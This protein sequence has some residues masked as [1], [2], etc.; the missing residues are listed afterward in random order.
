VSARDGASGLAE[1]G[2]VEA[3]SDGVFSIVIT[4]LVLD[5]HV[6]EQR[7]AMLAGLE[8]QWPVYLAYLASFSYVGVIWVNH[9]QLFTR[10]G[11]VDTGLLWRNLALL[12]MTS[13]LPFPTAVLG[14]AFVRGD[15]ADRA[16]GVVFYVTV[17][18][19]AV[20]MWLFLYHYLARNP[21]LLTDRR[22]ASFFARERRRAGLGP[23]AYLIVAL[24]AGWLSIVSLP[25]AP[26]VRAFRHPT[27]PGGPWAAG[28]LS[29]PPSIRRA[30]PRSR[31]PRIWADT[32]R[33]WG[34]RPRNG[35]CR[36]P[37][38]WV[39]RALAA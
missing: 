21:R 13:V 33:Y 18:G 24:A 29:R 20:L 19:A 26:S 8:S 5:L 15:T 31:S 36:R 9:H 6:P 32:I 10:I 28:V 23:A 12:F 22:H 3:F 38:E 7:G 17:A 16:A 34:F 35:T 25:P 11:R 4:L 39:A 14:T 27:V 30:R 1:T 2:R 37:D